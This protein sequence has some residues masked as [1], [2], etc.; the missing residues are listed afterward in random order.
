MGQCDGIGP[1]NVFHDS[2]EWLIVAGGAH[3]R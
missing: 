1:V 3:Q 2:Q